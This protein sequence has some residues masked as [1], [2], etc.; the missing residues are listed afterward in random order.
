MDEEREQ[1]TGWDFDI[2]MKQKKAENGSTRRYSG[3]NR[4]SV[5]YPTFFIRISSVYQTV[6]NLY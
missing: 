1:P 6:S 4:M 2:M 3:V 5:G